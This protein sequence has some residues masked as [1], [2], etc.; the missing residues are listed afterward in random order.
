MNL[1]TFVL[2]KEER[3]GKA[4]TQVTFD[5]DYNLPD[6][7]PDVSAIICKHGNVRVEEV[8]VT[9]GH[10]SVK[11]LLKFEIL[12]RGGMSET[13]ISCLES[14]FPFQETV[15]V[16]EAQEF[17]TALVNCQLEDL[18]VH[19]TNSRKLAVRALMDLEVTV[20]SFSREEFP[21]AITE[22]PGIQTQNVKQSFLELKGQGRDQCRVHE[23]TELP[24]NK[25]NIQEILWKQIQP[26]GMRARADDG[27]LH[28]QWDLQIFV[29]Y[30]VESGGRIEWYETRLP[31]D[32]RLDVAEAAPEDICYAWIDAREWNLQ[33][34]EDLE[35]ENRLLVID[36][37]LRVDYRLY[38]EQQ[39]DMLQDLYALDRRLLPKQRQVL[40]E[41]LLLKNAT[42]C[43]V[44]DVLSLE[45][46]QKDV[47]QMCSC[48]GQIQ[49]DHC[50]VEDG[51]IL[52]E[53]AVQVLILYFTREDHTPLDA[54]EGVLPFSQRVDVPGIQKGYRYELTANMEM[55]SAM[56]KDNSTFEVQAVADLDVIVFEPRQILRI[57]QVEEMPLN[58]EE[59]LEQPGMMG[60]RTEEGDTLWKIAKEN[61]TTVEKIQQTNDLPP[62]PVPAGTS[63]LLLKQVEMTTGGT[64]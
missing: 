17:D 53:G 39:R 24:A 55:M 38:E 15:A 35:G 16:D 43:K 8:K 6:Y 34:Q 59:L 58:M 41:T 20:F 9:K 40:M 25:A 44:N 21:Q 54:V 1:D 19:I 14:T 50:S 31:I 3:K 46:G 42:R 12:Y 61:H 5:E 32:C 63:I 64:G 10:V 60:I 30:S 4:A 45:R 2:H 47:L 27:V 29:L 26:Q 57:E 62:E 56:M 23:E 36:G 13:G 49:I 22:Q 18:S 37:T 7:K 33:V 51:G 52:V 11:G 48:C 28:I